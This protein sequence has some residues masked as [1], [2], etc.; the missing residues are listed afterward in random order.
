MFRQCAPA[1]CS[2]PLG[3]SITDSAVRF[4][5]AVKYGGRENRPSGRETRCIRYHPCRAHHKLEWARK[6]RRIYRASARAPYTPGEQ[7]LSVYG[8]MRYCRAVPDSAFRI[9]P[10]INQSGRGSCA[11]FI[12]PL[13]ERLT[14]PESGAH[15]RATLCGLAATFLITH[16]ELCIIHS[17]LAF[18]TT[19]PATPPNT[20]QTAPA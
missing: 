20:H 8:G 6:L 3:G 18:V 10:A 4:T 12:A 19:D 5:P 9:P 2:P 14:C 11:V 15:L 7:H 16:Y 13:H 17:V 1:P